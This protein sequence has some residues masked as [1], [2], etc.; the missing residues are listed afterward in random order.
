MRLFNNQ[1]I[2]IEIH[3]GYG[4]LTITDNTR[5][6]IN[7][8]I[9]VGGYST[10]LRG[11]TTIELSEDTHIVTVQGDN[12]ADF[13]REITII[14]GDEEEIDLSSTQLTAGHLEL[15]FIDADNDRDIHGV[16]VHVDGE[17][18]NVHNP[19]LLAFGSYL[20]QAER[21]G[22]MPKE[23]HIQLAEGSSPERFYLQ[24]LD[25]QEEQE[26]IGLPLVEMPAHS[27]KISRGTSTAQTRNDVLFAFFMGV[28]SMVVLAVIARLFVWSKLFPSESSDPT[29]RQPNPDVI[30]DMPGKS[31]IRA[32]N[33][34]SR[35]IGNNS[36]MKFE[37]FAGDLI[38]ITGESG[39]GKTALLKILAGFDKE[40]ST[41]RE[42]TLNFFRTLTWKSNDR[43]L[44]RRIGFVPQDA[45][46]YRKIKPLQLL[47]Y[48]S[49]MFGSKRQPYEIEAMLNNLGKTNWDKHIVKLSGGEQKRVSFAIEFLRDPEI[50]ILDEPDSGLDPDNCDNLYTILESLCAKG[51]AVILSTHAQSRLCNRNSLI[52]KSVFPDIDN[53]RKDITLHLLCRKNYKPNIGEKE[54]SDENISPEATIISAT[55]NQL[56]KTS[57]NS[58]ANKIDASGETIFLDGRTVSAEKAAAREEDRRSQQ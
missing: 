33:L 1:V 29:T 50:F 12:I 13:I 3:Q 5:R 46:L 15:V 43:E 31:V 35:Y 42:R 52:S 11:N 19:R 54:V 51:K 8:L 41:T 48:Y 10:E 20:V 26:N 18:Y 7:G 56:H 21:S 24:G 4:T 30:D 34:T 22:F 32:N 2:F 53:A 47:N 6:V 40:E 58:S 55:L 25:T 49:K 57:Q 38:Y 45:I 27:D 17:P 9:T 37:V 16:T 14:I 36:N 23:R 28:V 44:K 39:A